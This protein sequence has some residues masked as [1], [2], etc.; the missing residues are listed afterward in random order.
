MISPCVTSSFNFCLFLPQHSWDLVLYEIE[1]L[2]SLAKV[3]H[4]PGS[5]SKS[6]ND[7]APHTPGRQTINF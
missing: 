6:P 5:L 1:I 3:L 4:F 2:S 7:A